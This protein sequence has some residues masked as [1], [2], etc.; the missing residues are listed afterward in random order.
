MAEAQQ[1]MGWRQPAAHQVLAAHG[2]APARGMGSY[3]EVRAARQRMGGSHGVSPCD[4][5]SP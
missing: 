5:G 1:R 3:R 2:M 4:G